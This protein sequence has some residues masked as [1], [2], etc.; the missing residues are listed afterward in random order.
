KAFKKDLLEGINMIKGNKFISTMISLGT[1]IN[2]VIAPIFSIGLIFIIKEVLRAT[3]FQFGIFQMVLSSS[4]LLAPIFSANYIKKINV[5]KLCYISFISIALFILIMSP[6]PSKTIL[7]R[8]DTNLIPY[9][10]MLII[11]F[12]V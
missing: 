9:I 5:G 2:F 7:D 1:I 8:L 10:L 3:D 12:M 6:I 4:M 11:S